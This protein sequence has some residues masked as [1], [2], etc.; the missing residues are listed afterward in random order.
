MGVGGGGG[1]LWLTWYERDLGFELSIHDHAIDLFVTMVGWVDVLDSDWGDFR[2]QHAVDISSSAHKYIMKNSH[3]CRLV[4][5]FLV[6]NTD[7]I[8]YWVITF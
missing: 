4:W 2:R 7:L 8:I 6:E 5:K 1:G 3:L